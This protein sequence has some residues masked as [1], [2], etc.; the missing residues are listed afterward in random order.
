MYTFIFERTFI[1]ILIYF[2]TEGKK[3]KRQKIYKTSIFKMNLI[4]KLSTTYK[5][6]PFVSQ[7][8]YFHDEFISPP[9]KSLKTEEKLQP[10]VSAKYQI[11][12]DENA[13]VILDVNEERMKM[14]TDHV[15]EKPTSAYEG[16]NLESKVKA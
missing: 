2:P 7:V 8:K 11:F 12:R 5:L 15:I 10:A 4:K 9:V 1:Y 6:Q 14:I 3:T 16:I 13:S